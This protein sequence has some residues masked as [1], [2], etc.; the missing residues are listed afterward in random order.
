MESLEKQGHGSSTQPARRP[1]VRK[2]VT[3]AIAEDICA[4]RYPSGSTLPRENDLC[5]MYGVS[6]TV[7]RESLKVLESKGLVRGK[8]R[9]GTSVCN[10]D[11]WNILDQDVLQWM[12]P[13]I[14]DFDILGSILEARRTI[15]PAAAEYAAE[16]AT[17][18][19]IADLENAWQQMR[20]SGDDP[21]GFT[22]ADV[23]FHNVLLSASHNQVFRRLSSAMHA[24]LKY[25][26]HAS[27]VAAHSR[28]EAIAVHGEL[29]EAL[30]LRDR[31]AARDC[32]HRM[33]DLAARD[34]AVE[35][36]LD[37]GRKTN[38]VTQRSA[39]SRR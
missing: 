23:I 24:G 14:A 5:E 20:D 21:E 15:E 26:L 36:R 25:A 3:A 10:K 18:R 1:R 33:L 31:A 27:N 11:D 30:R 29:V 34:L 28:D 37:E 39:A 16:R 6:R 2:N 32:A 12:G 4:E 19:E 7:I 13:F 17:A 8:P 22:E 9:I 38:P 35:R